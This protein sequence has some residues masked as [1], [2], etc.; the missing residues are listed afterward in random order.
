[1]GSV[2]GRFDAWAGMLA[3]RRRAYD[4]WHDRHLQWHAR[5]DAERD[6]RRSEASRRRA[7]GRGGARA[8]PGLRKRLLLTFV[9]ASGLALVFSGL[10]MRWVSRWDRADD[11]A[12]VLRD[13]AAE[14]SRELAFGPDG[15]PRAFAR[16]PR[17]A[18]F[19]ATAPQ[20]WKY[21]V[22]DDRGAAVL[23]SDAGAPALAPPGRGF[24][25]AAR[26]FGLAGGVPLQVVTRR[27][28]HDG[29]PYFVQ[30]AVSERAAELVGDVIVGPVLLKNAA[31]ISV[32]ALVLFVIGVHMSLDY[33][34]RP[35]REGSRAAARIDPRNLAARLDVGCM[36]RELLP[37]IT[38]FNAALDRLETGYRT[39]QEFLAAAAHELKTPLALIRGQ[40]ELS[41]SCERETLL[42]DID[43]MA[44]Q[45][46][47]L[48]HLAEASEVTNYSFE[49]LD[50][51][52]VV[53]QA[54]DL[55]QRLAQR[56][57]VHV[58]VRLPAGPLV[59]QADRSAVFVLA[60]NLVE[61]AIQ[62]SPPGAVVTVTV[63]ADGLSVRDEG[64]GI[65]PEHLDK[66]FTRFWRGPH[67]RDSG[68][69]LG[70]AICAEVAIA[71]DWRL[72]AANGEAGGA[73]FSVAFDAR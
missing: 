47:Q 64:P 38:A 45:V 11:V 34:L 6:A 13:A 56:A 41:D 60:K 21:R 24:D 22:L 44:R 18:W 63:A 9:C 5:R 33:L 31:W 73:V 48:L 54:V 28:E 46:H 35:L 39:Q 40:V 12:Y 8:G 57:G 25:P 65:P 43:L 26:A 67:R 30:V 71:H 37:L 16:T 17:D 53:A 55:L 36:P 3:A 50:V 51:G 69:G 19:Y 20:D 52:A 49:A 59:R 10:A 27:Y 42:R 70:L 62:H 58:D 14:L 72:A 23:S 61:N 4:E 68:A 29:R 66:L 15:R 2:K 7:R 1:M 32:V